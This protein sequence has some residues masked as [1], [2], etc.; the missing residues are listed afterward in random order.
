VQQ[1]RCLQ[2]EHRRRLA[3]VGDLDHGTGFAVVDQERLISLAAQIDGGA[4]QAEQ[5]LGDAGHLGRFKPRRRLLE[6]VYR[7]AADGF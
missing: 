6:H 5:P 7:P 1:R 3:Q 2:V 4:G